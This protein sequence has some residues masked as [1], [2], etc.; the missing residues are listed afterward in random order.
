[1]LP[2]LYAKTALLTDF[3]ANNGLG[4]INT[5]TKCEI[6]E[7][8]N[9]MYE[10]ELVIS[11][12]DAR[13][14]D[15][16]PLAYVKAKA[17]PIDTPQVFEIYSVERN[18]K[19]TTVRAAHIRYRLNGNAFEEPYYPA[20]DMTPFQVWTDIQDVLAFSTS[21]FTFTSDIASTLRPTAA[22]ECPVRLGEFLLGKDGSLLDTYGGEYHFNN[23]DIEFKAARGTVRKSVLRVGAGIKGLDYRITTDNCYTALLPYCKLPFVMTTGQVIGDIFV[24][25]GILSTTD[26]GETN[27][28]TYDRTLSYDF[29]EDILSNYPQTIVETSNGSSPT[30]ESWAEALTKLEGIA[31]HYITIMK[32]TLISPE[33]QITIDA[34]VNFKPLNSYG[35]CDT[36]KA[37]YEPFNLTKTLKIVRLTYDA[38]AERVVSIDLAA[39]R[40]DLSRLF[41]SKNIGGD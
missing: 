26:S 12:F 40:R 18:E 1:M 28:L 34:Q 35:L 22:K 15:I 30:A 38:L 21:P 23:F 39:V 8:R 13:I 19:T 37:F 32:Q 20:S 24:N 27:I 31:A 6:V 29:T 14:D 17:N 9:G 3:S 25:T 11:S 33:I 4:F 36:V 2:I 7:E 10:L 16:V 5:A 41:T